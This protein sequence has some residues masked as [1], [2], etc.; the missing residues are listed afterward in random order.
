MLDGT[1]PPGIVATDGFREMLGQSKPPTWVDST[2][3]YGFG[4]FVQPLNASFTWYHGGAN[5]GSRGFFCRFT[6]GGGF[7]YL[8][9]GDA[10]D[11]A[12]LSAYVTQAI[13]NVLANVRAWPQTDL[14]PQ[15]YPPR[16]SPG[17]VV[18]AVTYQSAQVGPG[19]IVAI[20]G[21][22]LGGRDS[23]AEV[24]IRDAAGIEHTLELLYSGPHQINT[25][26]PY[27][28]ASGQATLT[29]NRQPWPDAAASIIL[30]ERSAQ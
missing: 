15:Y 13:I 26:I 20:F 9:N 17:G 25:R 27:T 18:D 28:A 22:D 5:P 6:N 16:I 2:A 11:G 3:W 21:V 12:S 24:R 29:V 19:S 10:T 14:F 4:L 7:A 23:A 30:A 8:F 1:R